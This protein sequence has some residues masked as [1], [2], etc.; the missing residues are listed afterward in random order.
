MSGHKNS[1]LGYDGAGDGP[2]QFL[3][4]KEISQPA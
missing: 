4:V 1:G 2:N 3:T